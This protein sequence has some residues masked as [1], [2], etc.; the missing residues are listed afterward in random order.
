MEVKF[1][2]YLLS[3]PSARIEA[4]APDDGGG[5][6]MRSYKPTEILYR[7]P[8]K[9][10]WEEIEVSVG[11]LSRELLYEGPPEISLYWGDPS[12]RMKLGAV[13]VPE[14]VRRLLILIM[15]DRS[16]GPGVHLIPIPFSG[17]EIAGGEGRFLNLGTEDLA[18]RIGGDM[19]VLSFGESVSVDLGQV[20]DFYLPVQF[21]V[22]DP[23]G[24]WTVRHSEKLI[25]QPELGYLFV[26]YSVPGLRDR[27]RILKLEVPKRADD[28]SPSESVG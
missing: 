12:R 16:S 25:V 9:D 23:T 7:N 20:Q 19:K 27:L 18:S 24:G 8:G 14:G 5:T 26:I 10:S 28:F 1:Q 17:N 21:A 6:Q 3:Q 15:P 13:R 11:R 22:M 2:V 4:A